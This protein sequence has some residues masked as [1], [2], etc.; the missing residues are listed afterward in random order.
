MQLAPPN[1]LSP[2]LNIPPSKTSHIILATLNMDLRMVCYTNNTISRFME[3]LAVGLEAEYGRLQT[4]KKFVNH[5]QKIVSIMQ[6][7]AGI[8]VMC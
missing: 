6:S 8:C 1:Q 2:P 4:N 7:R 5:M 3:C